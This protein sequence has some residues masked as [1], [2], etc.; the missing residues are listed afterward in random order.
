MEIIS[1]EQRVYVGSIGVTI[2]LTCRN[3]NYE[4]VDL[5][6]LKGVSGTVV[7]LMQKPD[8]TEVSKAASIVGTT[9]NTIRFI[10]EDGDF[11]DPGIYTFH[12]KISNSN[13]TIFT[14]PVE[15]QVR[16]LYDEEEIPD[17][18]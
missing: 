12:G 3:Y 8:G 11:D 6:T 13:I 2:D 16:N 15:L 18:V 14:E 1:V 10:S 7:V 17:E 5:D 4:I 9:K